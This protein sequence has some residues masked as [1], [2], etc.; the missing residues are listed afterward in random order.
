MPGD[1][2][3]AA[4]AAFDRNAWAEA[5]TAFAIADRQ[6]PLDPE[7]L[8][9]LGTAA[10]L[11]GEDQTGVDAWTRAHAGF[12]ERGHLTCA[13]R[14][15]FWLAFVLIERPTRRAE[16][17]G[18][19]A[20]AQ[21]LI[22][23]CGAD[24][25]EQGLLLCLVAVQRAGGGDVGAAV[26]AFE[27]AAAVGA[28][29]RDPDVIALARHGLGRG[30]L[31]MNRRSEGFALLDEV[32]IAVTTG[33]VMPLVAGVIYCSVIS[34]CYDVFDLR[35][36]QEWT[37]ALSAWCSAHP[38]M[39]AFR[40][41]CLV[42]RSELLQLHGAW[43]AALAE[44][45]RA[46]GTPG[47]TAGLVAAAWYQQGELCRLR[48]KFS[49][50]EDAFRRASHAGRTPYPGFAWLRLAQGQTEAA[51]AAVQRMLQDAREPRARGRLLGPAVEIMLA[52]QQSA[53]A[54]AA[55]EELAGIAAAFD[56]PLLQ[57]QAAQ[58]AG[59][60]ALAAGDASAAL[61][62]LREAWMRWQELEAP[63]DVACVRVLM[64]T[65]YRIL[66]DEEG[67]QLEFEA[68]QEA[69]EMLGAAPDVARVTLLV[70]P[71]T[72]ASGALTGREVEVL[73]M[74]ATGKTNRAIAAELNISEKTVA[75]HL[76]NIFTK[77]DLSSRAAA[78]AYAYEHHLV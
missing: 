60:V 2:L 32:M 62:R 9:R 10:Y 27:D 39:M 57:A 21:R 28:R 69:F 77:L 78:T 24:C 17:S 68:A 76:S 56:A 49:E 34:A 12:R 38:D 11:V 61:E 48:G 45:R 19:L 4:R 14:T 66:G 65:A 30:L 18:W 33:E 16:A 58:A 35:R 52:L 1:A 7:D 75:R 25:R 36:A 26:A 70:A 31:R 6:R 15:A 22:E 8:E 41:Q 13:A 5:C 55:A 23:E 54:R 71:R 59:A 63:Y 29:F 47:E 67:A 43:E 51:G 53:P 46:G 3:L 40:G 20:R 73:R 37:A 64:G 50:A 42:R 74:V 72:A 44:A